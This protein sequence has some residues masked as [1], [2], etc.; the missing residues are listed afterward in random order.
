MI[1][2]ENN[3]VNENEH[4]E[5]SENRKTI[6][7]ETEEPISEDRQ[8]PDEGDSSSVADTGRTDFIKRPTRSNTPL[9][10]SHEPGTM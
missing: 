4:T 3:N 9:G 5:D 6:Y 8:K 10:S 1:T 7:K 2:P